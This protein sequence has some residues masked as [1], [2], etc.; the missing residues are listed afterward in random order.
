MANSH[1]PKVILLDAG[2]FFLFLELCPYGTDDLEGAVR[3]SSHILIGIFLCVTECAPGLPN[4]PSL[5]RWEFTTNITFEWNY[6]ATKKR[7][8]WP[9]L[10]RLLVVLIGRRAAVV[11]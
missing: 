9:L 3:N 10:V 5:S 4:Q 1:D 7:I 6:V 8:R 11:M 2:R